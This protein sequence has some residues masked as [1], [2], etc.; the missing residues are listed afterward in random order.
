LSRVERLARGIAIASFVAVAAGCATVPLEQQAFRPGADG[1]VASR[2]LRCTGAAHDSAAATRAALP[3]PTLRVLSWNLHKNEDPGWD[4]DLARFAAASDLVLIQ[5]AALTAE[6]QRVLAD[7][8]FDWLLAS[9]FRFRGLEMGVLSAARVPSVAGC[10]QRFFE[11][12]LQ[13]PK[14]TVIT[15][16]ALPGT[17]RTLAVANVHAINF[18]LTLGGYRAQLEAIAAELGDHP[19]PAIVAGDL[20]TWSAARLEVVDEVMASIGLKPVLP[21]ND[22]RTR[23]LGQQVDYVFVRGLDVVHAEAPAVDSSDHNPV[24]ATLRVRDSS[25]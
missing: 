17:D 15:R 3:G 20:N 5:E 13:L 4:R 12:L 23:F 11:P 24:L 10:T 14:S 8:G 6:L 22:T 7:A 1:N 9:S 16:Y 2:T 21:P 18:S 19:G 25:P